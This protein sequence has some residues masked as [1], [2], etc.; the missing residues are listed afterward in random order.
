MALL[1]KLNAIELGLRGSHKIR[2]TGY[3]LN[4]DIL[5]FLLI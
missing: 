3:D 5:H 1:R 4:L 2:I